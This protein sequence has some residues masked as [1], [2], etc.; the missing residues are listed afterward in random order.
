MHLRVL[1]VAD[2]S[3][4]NHKSCLPTGHTWSLESAVNTREALSIVN[5]QPPFDVVVSQARTPSMSHIQLLE[6]V[7]HRNPSA[8]RLILSETLNRD[9]LFASLGVVHQVVRAPCAPHSIHGAIRRALSSD[10]SL[11]NPSL[12]RALNRFTHIPHIPQIYCNVIEAL[13]DPE[14]S[15]DD[16]ARVVEEDTVLAMRILHMVNS[17]NFE[18]WHD[19]AS[20]SESIQYLGLETITALVLSIGVFSQFDPSGTD[21]WGQSVWRHSLEV[22]TLARKIA[23]CE[24]VALS[25]REDAFV[26]GLL[27]DVGKLIIAEHSR[28]ILHLMAQGGQTGRLA[29]R[30]LLDTDHAECWGY[31][32]GLWGLSDGVV[33]AIVRHHC[34]EHI[35]QS[36]FSTNVALTVANCLVRDSLDSIRDWLNSIGLLERSH[37]W[38]R[39]LH[40]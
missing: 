20:V 21:P 6:T 30:Q 1:F 11:N 4:T 25:T 35:G 34:I 19:I 39:L 23:S 2:S 24:S 38:E 9:T 8:V 3:F 10:L 26:A 14:A 27:H 7:A 17:A 31:L 16:I 28:D 18:L 40:S 37:A 32:V 33:E 13:R 29:E 22:A 36:G 5:R 15:I 12:V